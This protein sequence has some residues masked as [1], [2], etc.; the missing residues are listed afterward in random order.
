MYEVRIH[1]TVAARHIRPD[2]IKTGLNFFSENEEYVQLGVWGH[3]SRGKKLQEHIH[4]KFER[5]S[6]RTYE[7]LYV[8]SGSLEA[9][10][11]DLDKNFVEKVQVNQGEIL[12]L[13]ECGHGYKITSED[14]TVI[15]M[16]NGPFAGA[17]KDRYRF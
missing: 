3:Y 2:D 9:S 16:K 13:L 14:T 11:Y 5:M 15:E 6:D 8:V 17:E 4:N 10:I 1:G 12:M 7:I